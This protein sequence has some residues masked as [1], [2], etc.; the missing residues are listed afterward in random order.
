MKLKKIHDFLDSEEGKV[1]VEKWISK[2]NNQA[3][4]LTIQL[5]R[6]YRKYDNR[7]IQFVDKIVCKYNSECYIKRWHK[8]H[9][10]PPEDLYWFLFEYAERYGREATNDEFKK[11]GNMFTSAMFYIHG[12][13]ISR[14]DGQ[15]SVIH[16]DKET[17]D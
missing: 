10:E 13:Y 11:Y 9:I 2:I 6:A 17:V 12:V 1:E 3:T 16:I 8:R 5:D 4:I 15:G 7:F 14:M